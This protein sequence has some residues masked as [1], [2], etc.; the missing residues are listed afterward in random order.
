MGIRSRWAKKSPKKMKTKSR[1]MEQVQLALLSHYKPVAISVARSQI[2]STGRVQIDEILDKIGLD[3]V[4]S[5]NLFMVVN[6][7]NVHHIITKSSASKCINIELLIHNGKNDKTLT[8]II[9]NLPMNSKMTD[10]RDTVNSI[11]RRE[12]KMDESISKLIVSGKVVKNFDCLLGDYI[13]YHHYWNTKYNLNHKKKFVIDAFLVVETAQKS[14]NSRY[15]E[16]MPHINDFNYCIPN[17]KLCKKLPQHYYQH[18]RTNTFKGLTKNYKK[19]NFCLEYAP[20][21]V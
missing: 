9:L 16:A 11:M 2:N 7:H 17:K 3:K 4:Y 15:I 21:V 18:K 13:L 20:E 5:D 14:I 19:L 8:K 6:E 1:P 12:T 10:V